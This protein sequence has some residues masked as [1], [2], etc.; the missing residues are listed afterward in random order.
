MLSFFSV[1]ILSAILSSLL[2]SP[3]LM[4]KKK[5][6]S[7][8]QRWGE[9]RKKIDKVWTPRWVKTEENEHKGNEPSDAAQVG[10]MKKLLLVVLSDT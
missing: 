1:C 10:L 4:K 5:K 2:C 6:M 7:W 8:G 3:E 9:K